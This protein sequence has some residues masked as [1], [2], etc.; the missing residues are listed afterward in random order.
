MTSCG[1]MTSKAV[2][3][4]FRGDAHCSPRVGQSDAECHLRHVTNR[5]E[6][7]VWGGE[8]TVLA[9][10]K[11]ACIAKMQ[12]KYIFSHAQEILQ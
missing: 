10:Q 12:C 8:S 7:E 3:A 4:V 9:L 2:A 5:A 11:C 1:D 6:T